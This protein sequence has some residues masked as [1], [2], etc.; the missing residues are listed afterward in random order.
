MDW[1]NHPFSDGDIEKLEVFRDN[2][3][4]ARLKL[5]FI[6]LLMLAEK[7]DPIIIQRIAGKS[8]ATIKRWFEQYR[9]NGVYSL[10]SFQ[11]KPK[12]TF[13]QKKQINELI[14][15]I[16][17]NRPSTGKE[18]QNHI[19][20][21]YQIR[22]SVDAVRKLIKKKSGLHSSEAYSGESSH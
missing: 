19:E 3:P 2:Q 10:N 8:Q 11:Y 18:I 7:V 4:D 15:W 6:V 13:L 21:E 1:L 20:K 22:Y 12:Q 9:D 17:E 16:K 5:R 14:T